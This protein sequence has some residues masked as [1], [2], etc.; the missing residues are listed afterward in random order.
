VSGAI[1]WRPTSREFWKD[2]ALI[3]IISLGSI[4]FIYRMALSYR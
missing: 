1:D 3:G 2:A 4:A